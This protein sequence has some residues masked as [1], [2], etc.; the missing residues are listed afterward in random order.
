MYYGNAGASNQQNPS[1]VWDSNYVMVHHLK[2]ASG[3]HSDSTS[4]GNS[5]TPYNGVVQGT[6]GKIDGSDSFDGSDDYLKATS[7]SSINNV[8]PLTYEC[9]VNLDTYGG[10]SSGRFFDKGGIRLFFAST[11]SVGFLQAFSTTNGQWKTSSAL[12]TAQWHHVV[13]T[14]D[15]SSTSNNPKIYVDGISQTVS[16]YSGS[17]IPSGTATS[18]SGNDLIMANRLNLQRGFDGIMDEIRMSKTER[19]AAWISTEYHNQYN[20][21][22]FYTIGSEEVGTLNYPPEISNESPADRATDVALNPT[23]QAHI[24]DSHNDSVDWAIEANTTGTWVTLNSG[25][26][27]SG[28]G[29]VSA[30]TS[31]MNIYSTKYWWKVSASD[32]LG[33]GNTTVKL[34]SFTTR[35]SNY[36]PSL[37]NPSPTN[38][39]TDVITNPTLS[40]DAS[41]FEGD[42]MTIVF[43]T[44]ASGAWQTLGTFYNAING[45]Y[46]QTTT[47]MNQFEK[48]YYWSASVKDAGSGT[49]TNKTYSFTTA[50]ILRLKYS[51]MLPHGGNMLPVVGDIN[52]DGIMEIVIRSNGQVSAIRGTDGAIL[53]TRSYSGYCHAQLAD[54]NND[55]KMEILVAIDGSPCGVVALYGD[56]SEYWR[57][58]DLGGNRVSLGPAIS[59]ADTDRDGF[60]EVYFVSASNAGGPITGEISV[61]SHDGQKLRSTGPVVYYPCWGGMCLGDYDFDGEFEI[62]VGERNIE[63]DPLGKGVR[64]WWAS[65][66]THRWDQIHILTSTNPPILADANGDGKLD[67]VVNAIHSGCAVVSAADGSFMIDDRSIGLDS[68]CFGAVYDIDEDG[69]LELTISNGQDNSQYHGFHVR[70]LAGRHTDASISL[71]YA[72]LWPPRFGDVTGDGKME[73]IA[74]PGFDGS[75]ANFDIFIYNKTFGLIAR[76]PVTGAGC[77]GP[78][79]TADVDGD[80]LNEVVVAG[81]TGKVLVY[82]TLAPTPVPR[83]RTELQG[84][85]QYLQGA[86]KY[87][88]PP[89][90]LTPVLSDEMPRDKSVNMP[91]NPTLSIRAFDY[92]SDSMIVVFRTNASGSWQTIGTYNGG[93]GIYQQSTTNM[94]SEATKYYWEARVTDSTGKLTTRICS[95]TTYTFNSTW[96]NAN[97]KYRK[98]ITIDHTKVA[99]DLSNF[100]ILIELTDASLASHAQ[101]DGD[102]I[103]FVD[104]LG[105]KLDHEIEYFD[106]VT[107]KLITWIRIPNL[108]SSADTMLYMYYGNPAS[109]NQENVAGVWGSD[110]IMVQHFDETSGAHFDSTSN[111]NDCSPQNGVIQGTNGKIDGADSFDGNDDVVTRAGMLSGSIGSIYTLSVWINLAS[112]AG[113]PNPRIIELDNLILFVSAGPAG[114]GNVVNFVSMYHRWSSPSVGQWCSYS[115]TILPTEGWVYITATYDGSSTANDALIYKNGAS[116][117][118]WEWNTPAGSFNSSYTNLCIG[119]RPVGDRSYNGKIDEVRISNNIRSA[120]WIQTEYNN[121]RDPTSFYTV[122]SEEH[123][124]QTAI[125]IEPVSTSI[126]L[127]EDCI[128]RVNVTDVTDLYAWELQLNYNKTILDLT[129]ILV[130]PGGLNT[131]TNTYHN[132]TDEANGHIWWAAST[133]YPTTTG[134]SYVQHAI[135]ELRFRAIGAGTSDISLY[136]TYLSDSK[137][138]P[139]PH[140]V[141]NGSIIVTGTIDL[142]IVSVNILDNGC[143]IYKD[144]TYVN[145]TPYY[146]PVEVAIQNTGTISANQFHLKLEVYWVTGSATEAYQEIIVSSLAGG[147]TTVIN[148]T[149]LFHPTH[150]GYYRLIATVDSRNEVVENNETNNIMQKDNIKVTVMGD[151]NGD[152]TVN[153]LDAVAIALAWGSTPSNPWWDIK[154]DINHDGKVDIYDGTRIGLHWAESW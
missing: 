5:A 103:V 64:S 4:N 15:S 42:L 72:C 136:S 96:W 112:F 148:F 11:D 83:P 111:N 105:S 62:Y 94:G 109:P 43:R 39:A 23:L 113:D 132:L 32:P 122:G 49:W 12:S 13:V 19:S 127:G 24:Y 125:K 145:G 143:S 141:A 48:K 14:Y 36:P 65:N 128:I 107:G 50:P 93:N 44:N 80:G 142:T 130:V 90:P 118:L 75:T 76:I 61:M 53:W 129:S 51:T 116:L 7:A 133:I 137:I 1:G 84:Y 123:L 17:T 70:D 21:S 66:L 147:S 20:P 87:I 119:D 59:V 63:Y 10:S 150:T 2:E 92:Q 73:I 3:T 140:T 69:R 52:G 134:I 110:F 35:P 99:G 33:S 139:I 121:Q 79:L 154:A 131:P 41:D 28:N 58:N 89:G 78:A 22:G 18:D 138:M 54:L 152:G 149:S 120:A 37:S 91:T 102:D 146:Y 31:N 101:S 67:I 46:N 9:W 81:C 82:D 117:S 114:T 30:P 27:P 106:K 77:L 126:L 151:I 100:P 124:P 38:G 6:S 85:S 40:I 153:I 135:L 74:A 45:S 88:P 8:N 55:G 86:A 57:R 56:G 47:T 34:Y 115:N 26:L 95:F 108:F 71:P 144:D 98:T 25:T 16:Y 60:L 29:T 68:H 104:Y 97:W